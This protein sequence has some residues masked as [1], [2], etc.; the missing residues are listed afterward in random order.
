[1]TS[2]LLMRRD[3]ARQNEKKKKIAKSRIILFFP[4]H[5]W[6]RPRRVG[7]RRG[8]V[9]TELGGRHTGGQRG[10][11]GRQRVDRS[12]RLADLFAATALPARSGGG[13]SDG[14]GDDC[15]DVEQT[16]AQTRRS[17]RRCQ[18]IRCDGRALLVARDAV[19]VRAF[20]SVLIL[21]TVPERG[22]MSSSC[23]LCKK[24]HLKCNGATPCDQC[25]CACL[26]IV[27]WLFGWGVL[28]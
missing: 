27:G 25:K 13:G 12:L 16:T 9:C 8:G 1:M 22:P 14:D 26:L 4:S 2:W 6:Q 24:G 23:D 18:W 21:F 19:A 3:H 11:G 7:I 20:R 28:L 17:W 10:D 15:R 5:G